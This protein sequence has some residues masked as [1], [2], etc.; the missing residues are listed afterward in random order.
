MFVLRLQSVEL[1]MILF[2]NNNKSIDPLVEDCI[3]QDCERPEFYTL[4]DIFHDRG[5]AVLELH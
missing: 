2:Q 1:N 5:S 4:L 3:R